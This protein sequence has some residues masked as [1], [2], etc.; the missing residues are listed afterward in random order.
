MKI[1]PFGQPVQYS[2]PP[3]GSTSRPDEAVPAETLDLSDRAAQVKSAG[4]GWWRSLAVAGM[5]ALGATAAMSPPAVAQTVQCETQAAM[6][7]QLVRAKDGT[8]VIH[9]GND[10]VVDPH[11]GSTYK[12]PGAAKQARALQRLSLSEQASRFGGT[13]ADG[14]YAEVPSQGGTVYLEQTS[15]TTLTAN[16]IELEQEAGGVYLNRPGTDDV[17]L[18]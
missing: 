5:L 15:P 2:G 10:R 7:F 8:V 4:G 17:L 3:R 14:I 16:S 9:V 11:N 6:P 18:R 1:N 13:S 12:L